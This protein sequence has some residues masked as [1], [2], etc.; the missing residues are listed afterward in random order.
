[1]GLDRVGTVN[2]VNGAV[3]GAKLAAIVAVTTCITAPTVKGTTLVCGGTVCGTTVCGTTIR[4][5]AGGNIGTGC[6]YSCDVGAIWIVC[7]K[8]FYR[9]QA[10]CAGACCWYQLCGAATACCC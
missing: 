9:G 3:T 7:G 5:C 4:T 8:L 2:I 1:M 10:A 6:Q